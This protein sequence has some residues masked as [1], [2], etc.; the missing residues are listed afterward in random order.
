MS[1]NV[2]VEC[3]SGRLRIRFPR[4]LF[5]GKQKYLALGLDDTPTNRA[6]A[7]SKIKLI[8]ADIEL[9][10]FDPTLAR[11]QDASARDEKKSRAVSTH[12]L[13]V[14]YAAYK[15]PSLSPKTVVDTYGPIGKLLQHGPQSL[16]K[17]LVLRSHLLSVTSEQMTRRVLMHL[18]AA[19]KWGLKHKL[20]AEN[21]FDGMYR[22]LPQPR[23]EIEEQANPFTEDERDAIIEAFRT[24]GTGR[25]GISYQFYTPLVHLG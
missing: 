12:Y 7:A 11:Y 4:K 22:E 17:P 14:K 23:Y 2:G 20:I 25:K 3:L 21:H 6:I 24:H 15:E 16:D 9:K 19:C 1:S 10:Q 18:S 5:G 8:E 13:W